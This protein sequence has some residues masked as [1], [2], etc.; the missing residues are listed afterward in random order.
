MKSRQFLLDSRNV[1]LISGLFALILVPLGIYANMTNSQLM[2]VT[3]DY[4][5]CKLDATADL[6]QPTIKSDIARWKYDASTRQCTVEFNIPSSLEKEVF[7]YIRLT[8]MFQ[9]A[10]QYMKSMDPGQ[11]D[12]V[13]YRSAA[14]IPS[15]LTSCAFLQ[16][17]N[18]QT[19]T[20]NTW[21]GNGLTHAQSNPDCQPI[22]TSRAPVINNADKDAQYYPC[23][24]IANSYFSG[25][26]G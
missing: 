9:N 23:G 26:F 10:R 20:E 17:A 16:Y 22:A 21:I 6:S 19:A 7:M 12:G 1:A 2:E 13:L 8:N 24:L 3:L 14:D 25:I 18:C 4:T 5:R 11:L 15:S